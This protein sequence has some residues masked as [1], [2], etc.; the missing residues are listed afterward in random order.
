MRRFVILGILL[1]AAVAHGS[2]KQT[3]DPAAAAK[4]VVLRFI[5]VVY[6]ASHP[7][8]IEAFV[9]PDFVDHSP[10][11]PEGASGPAWV[12]TQYAKTYAAFPDLRF[13]VDDVIA[14]GDEVVTRWSSHGTFSGKLGE[15]AG[16]G[17]KVMIQG[18]SIMRIADGKI[19]ESWD[20]VDRASM[21]RQ[22]GFVLTPPTAETKGH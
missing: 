18:I 15:V 22:V 11:V 5:D 13:T 14:E 16:K 19:I 12:H 21:F 7:D 6:N 1:V 17:Q 3:Q 4:A 9:H 20:L 2:G 10:G 8:S